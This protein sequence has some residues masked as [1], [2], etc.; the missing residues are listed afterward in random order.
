M[1]LFF[2][3]SETLT[4]EISYHVTGLL[5]VHIVL[6]YISFGTGCRQCWPKGK[7]SVPGGSLAD[8]GWRAY[9]VNIKMKCLQPYCVMSFN[10]VKK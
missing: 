7:S 5:S 2:Q 3:M 10:P 9:D 8:R 1:P 4:L 6:S